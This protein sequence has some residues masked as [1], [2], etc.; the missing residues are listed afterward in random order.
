MLADLTP[1]KWQFYW[2]LLWKLIWQTKCWQIYPPEMPMLEIP[3]LTAHF[4]QT[5]CWQIYPPRNGNFTYSYSDSSYETDQVL[6]DL[7]PPELAILEIPTL[8]AHI[9]QTKCGQIYPPQNGNCRF[10]LWE[11]I[12]GRPGVAGPGVPCKRPS[13]MGNFLIEELVSG[14]FS[15]YL[16]ELTLW[17]INIQHLFLQHNASYS[18]FW[19]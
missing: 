18:S 10:L 19:W 14:L 2:F 17:H 15:Y 4:R 7:P 6:A 3:I 16:P 13:H 9:R 8:T 12:F 11:L 1:Q 5:K